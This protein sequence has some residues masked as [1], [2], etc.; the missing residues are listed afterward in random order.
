M[1]SLDSK[2]SAEVL[3]NSFNLVFLKVY[4]LSYSAF[5]TRRLLC[6]FNFEFVS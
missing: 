6:H 4:L 2:R 1:E 3:S 5:S